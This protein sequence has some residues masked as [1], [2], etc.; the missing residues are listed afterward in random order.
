M[1]GA[2]F[3]TQQNYGLLTNKISQRKSKNTAMNKAC[4]AYVGNKATALKLGIG[5]KKELNAEKDR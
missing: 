5:S 3:N 2:L 1:D 4:L